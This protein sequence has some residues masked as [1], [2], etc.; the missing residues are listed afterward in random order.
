M[1]LILIVKHPTFPTVC[2]RGGTQKSEDI[3][4]QMRLMLFI[5]TGMTRKEGEDPD[6]QLVCYKGGSQEQH[7][8]AINQKQLAYITF[9]IK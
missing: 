8:A 1:K 2:R 6:G 9:D 5:T 3:N 4:F 7:Q